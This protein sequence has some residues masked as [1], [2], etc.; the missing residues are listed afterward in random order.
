MAG[1]EQEWVVKPDEARIDIAIGREAK[2][3]PE[4]REALDR[5]ARVLEQQQ[6]VQG[7]MNCPKVTYEENCAAY[8]T[9]R[10][11]TG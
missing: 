8:V 9:C 2:L 4:L 6:D 7:Y 1:D 11:V 5:I 3:S 10:G